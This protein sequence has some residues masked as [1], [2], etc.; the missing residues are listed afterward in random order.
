MMARRAEPPPSQGGRLRPMGYLHWLGGQIHTLVGSTRGWMAWNLLLAALPAALALVLFRATSSRGPSWWAGFAVFALLLP[1]APYVI[2]DLVH[3]REH[4][5]AAASDG[6]VV[7]G[8]LPLFAAFIGAGLLFY[9]VAV[10]L[11]VAEVIRRWPSLPSV[12]VVT[13]VHLVCSVGVVLG[14]MARLNSWDAVTSPRSTL[15][16]VLDTLFWRGAPAAVLAVFVATA[17][18]YGGMAGIVDAA[19]RALARV[20]RTNPPLA[21]S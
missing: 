17:I 10:R 21:A 16:L 13:A 6:V 19:M 5:A 11:F 9:V 18:G 7:F 3:L 8:V 12:L 20:R 1:N 2:T 4:V 15:S 14:R